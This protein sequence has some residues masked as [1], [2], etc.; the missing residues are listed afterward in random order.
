[1][2]KPEVPLE[3]SLTL[4]QADKKITAELQQFNFFVETT[5]LNASVPQSCF[6]TRLSDSQGNFLARGFGK[7]SPEEACVGSK[8]EAFETYAS[9][10]G[11]FPAKAELLSYA[12]VCEQDKQIVANKLPLELI[13]QEAFHHTPMAWVEYKNYFNEDQSIHIPAASINPFY[14]LGKKVPGDDFPSEKLYFQNSNNGVAIG[15]NHTEA[16]IHGI[17]EIIERDAISI[18]V[19][20]AFMQKNYSALTAINKDS[21]S[22]KNKT[23]IAQIERLTG[24]KA[25]ILKL[26]TPFDVPCYSVSV[27]SDHHLLPLKGFGA[28]L[29]DENALYRACSECL[30][31]LLSYE[32]VAIQE[33]DYTLEAFANLPELMHCAKFNIADIIEQIPHLDF[34]SNDEHL[35]SDLQHYLNEVVATVSATNFSLYHTILYQSANSCTVAI[36]IPEA[37]DLLSLLKGIIPTFGPR[38]RSKLQ[39]AA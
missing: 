18:L 19:V 2:I 12:Q 38:L 11:H 16:L 31:L 14:L 9:D 7:G 26:N 37:E 17:L 20:D 29:S 10:I 6:E 28:S 32:R 24:S 33:F 15:C 30:E 3:R 4:E 39:S 25:Y 27:A 5:E 23:L 21:I 1:M 35:P 34:S 8:F 13:N 36:T 22:D